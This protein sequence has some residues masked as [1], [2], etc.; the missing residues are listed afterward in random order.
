MPVLHFEEGGRV[1]E[2]K[3]VNLEGFRKKLA[4]AMS[5][6][7]T[8]AKEDAQYRCPHELGL[9]QTSIKIDRKSIREFDVGSYGTNY[10]EHVEFGTK[11]MID[12]HG[13][14]KPENPVIS[15]KA[16]R[17]RKEEG[18]G[19]TLPFLRPYAY[20]SETQRKDFKKGFV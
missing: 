12:A 18:M 9:L 13:E 16:L 3:S 19:Y 15:W 17:T 14:H 20:D 10:A 2:I 5:Y 4:H 11:I 7:S 8:E 6:V 1:I